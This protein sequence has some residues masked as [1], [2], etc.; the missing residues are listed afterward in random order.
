MD[1]VMMLIILTIMVV[2]S[3]TSKSLSI[4]IQIYYWPIIIISR[5]VLMFIDFEN[6]SFGFLFLAACFKG[7][8]VLEKI[9]RFKENK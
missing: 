5:I 9:N 8:G 4:S 2:L 6:V 1:I 7:L 3:M